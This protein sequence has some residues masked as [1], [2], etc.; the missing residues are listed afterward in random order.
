MDQPNGSVR[1]AHTVSVAT[2]PLISPVVLLVDDDRPFLRAC[3][4]VLRAA[5][6]HVITAQD[7]R[8]ALDAMADPSTTVDLMVVDVGLPDMSGEDMVRRAARP[9]PVL[10]M[11]GHANVGPR[12]LRKPFTAMNLLWHVAEL[13]GSGSPSPPVA[14]AA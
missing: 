2:M 3:A 8:T 12:G 1:F 5:R 7:G 4:H 10:Y 13:V 9:V 6:Y 11:S 14:P